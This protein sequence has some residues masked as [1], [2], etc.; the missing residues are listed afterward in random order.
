M[1][2]SYTYN[3]NI[4]ANV[5]TT[6]LDNVFKKLNKTY[7]I[8]VKFNSNAV[9]SFFK[10]LDKKATIT[11]DIK[12]NF[13]VIEN[14]IDRL[15][16]KAEKFARTMD[17]IGDMSA[18][19]SV[20]VD[21]GNANFN[22]N[23]GNLENITR[24]SVKVQEKLV[25]ATNKNTKET[26]KRNTS[27]APSG[28]T[29]P[30][31]TPLQPQLM[32]PG[33]VPSGNTSKPQKGGSNPKIENSVNDINKKIPKDAPS[34]Y[35][36]YHGNEYTP[37]KTMK[38]TGTNLSQIGE[39]Y[40]N[41]AGGLMGMGTILGGV[42]LTK[43]LVDTPAQA[44][45]N[46]WLLST[47][48]DST[49]SADQLYK[50]VDDTTNK[51]P[52]SM[53]DVVQPLYA[54]KSASGGTAQEINDIT[55][56]FAN[57]GAT[58]LNMTGSE[59]LAK[60]AM[61]KLAYGL[62]D[63]YAALDQYGITEDAVR[64]S[65]LW[66]GEEDDIEG[67]MK[68]VTEIAGDASKSM[69]TFT[70]MVAT[71][72]KQVSIA[73]KELWNSFTGNLLRSIVGG[74]VD[75]NNALGGLPA[76]LLLGAGAIATLGTGLMATIGYIGQTIGS[77]QMVTQDF[78]KLKA[79]GLRGGLKYLF[80]KGDGLSK[81]E[82]KK[83]KN[84]KVD[85][86]LVVGG[87][88][89]IANPNKS[90]RQRWKANREARALKDF[91]A[92]GYTRNDEI[93]RRNGK[94]S[95]RSYSNSGREFYT[96]SKGKTI[97]SNAP[98]NKN[99]LFKS[100]YTIKRAGTELKHFGSSVAKSVASLDALALVIA[101]ITLVGGAIHDFASNKSSHKEEYN[102]SVQNLMNRLSYLWKTIGAGFGNLFKSL[103]WADQ[104]GMEGVVEAIINGINVLNQIYD[105]V[106][107]V[108][109]SV[110]GTDIR[111]DEAKKSAIEKVKSKDK[112][113]HDEGVFEYRNQQYNNPKGAFA[114]KIQVAD[115][116]LTPDQMLTARA[117]Y[118]TYRTDLNLDN[119]SATDLKNTM[120]A[121]VNRQ[122]Y[123]GYVTKDELDDFYN[124]KLPEKKSSLEED[125]KAE[126]K[127]LKDV[128][129]A[130][131][132]TVPPVDYE[133]MYEGKDTSN[134][135]VSSF[136]SKNGA[137]KPTTA[138]YI[139]SGFTEY[140]LIG[141][142]I[143]GLMN[144][145]NIPTVQDYARAHPESAN[146]EYTK[147]WYSHP[148]GGI[149]KINSLKS[150]PFAVAES[151]GQLFSGSDKDKTQ[152]QTQTSS[153]GNGDVFG[154]V[155][156]AVDDFG[157]WLND[158]TKSDTQSIQDKESNK[159]DI[160]KTTLP[161]SDGT[162]GATALLNSGVIN[163]QNDTSNK[164]ETPFNSSKPT[165]V[166]IV[167][168][169]TTDTNNDFNSKTGGIT[170]ESLLGDIGGAIFNGVKMSLFGAL[171]GSLSPVSAT[172]VSEEQ[173]INNAYNKGN[174]TVDPN[175]VKKQEEATNKTTV[176]T[177]NFGTSTTNATSSI[178]SFKSGI[179]SFNAYLDQVKANNLNPATQQQGQQ[180]GQPQL[181]GMG[182]QTIQM[183]GVDTSNATS[184]LNTAWMN[185]NNSITTN[186]PTFIA[187][188]QQVA[189]QGVQ[190]FST[191]FSEAS[192]QISASVSQLGNSISTNF[193]LDGLGQKASQEAQKVP[194]AISN[195]QGACSSASSGLVSAINGAFTGLN[196]ASTVEAEM[197]HTLDIIN[198]YAP[199]IAAAAG[200]VSANSASNATGEMEQHSPGKI[201][202]MFGKEM[203]YSAMMIRKN[204]PDVINSTGNVASKSVSSFAR[205]MIPLTPDLVNNE[206]SLIS[207]GSKLEFSTSDLQA[208]GNAPRSVETKGKYNN[209]SQ[210]NAPTI[211]NHFNIDKIDTKERV[212]EIGET[213][214]K[215]MT[216]N[217]ETAGR[218][219]PDPFA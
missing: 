195:Q 133:K 124:N 75:L 62:D 215:M 89:P 35:N 87:S 90:R 211:T 204:A 113:T 13:K 48:A 67:Y 108:A 131:G 39:K 11:V 40:G 8:K 146:Q 199:Q 219:P 33:N 82:R 173:A 20:H 46:K 185:I 160:N 123:K 81:E 16:R 214:V 5:N 161:N 138:S 70:G 175:T 61:M 205:N 104:G 157:S 6:E 25:Y 58:V 200:Q 184:L 57:F 80:G 116:N 17:N 45:V 102:A 53:Q 115:E 117:A 86:T 197:K 49:A 139:L 150:A 18:S 94:M 137:E 136:S 43:A 59:E 109:E 38:R 88:T 51:L 73:G 194:Q 187:N 55:P 60:T 155:K 198:Q 135:E 188:M 170:L 176:S 119:M 15:Q 216:W 140:P 151:F 191:A 44:E 122:E 92:L 218:N 213:I 186:T 121:F 24:E 99:S 174:A 64:R 71:V 172:N 112:A 181:P 54:F 180:P 158:L 56:A 212:K 68:A 101:G 36:M 105:A 79:M 144:G 134:T 201:A 167:G 143:Q 91:Y 103:G 31:Y 69:G 148:L 74:F 3:V 96:F 106:I 154:G 72:R 127:H 120:M 193:N 210:T 142:W 162:I 10:K 189:S 145:A 110:T 183:P 156:K 42:E 23:T 1:A 14:K 178:D 27:K 93:L 83:L 98:K 63:K 152:N 4:K 129:E 163:N 77:F 149:G 7:A 182:N 208:I 206:A 159:K 190:S 203:M 207:R 128:S 22:V 217:N 153:T 95:R 97:K 168:N 100:S 52:I 141:G 196:I 111:K 34:K 192:P 30:N 37:A 2:G 130:S 19:R 125:V 65:G 166:N 41:F 126:D 21:R 26:R 114:R 209:S 179:A 28:T 85:P 84:Q 107:S 177:E 47:M 171:M 29:S 12:G 78:K 147:M 165:D 66:S 76:K 132:Y 202:R 50:T 164:N 9:D 118:E 169:N 32:L